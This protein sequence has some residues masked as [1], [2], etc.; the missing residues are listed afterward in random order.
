[1]RLE[2]LRAFLEVRGHRDK[3]SLLSAQMKSPI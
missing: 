3:G 2:I 1:M